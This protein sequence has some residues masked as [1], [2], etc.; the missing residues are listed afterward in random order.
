[1]FGDAVPPELHGTTNN[2]AY[3]H[4]SNMATVE[5]NWDLGN[6]GLGDSKAPAFF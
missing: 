5:R 3:N 4:Y 1:L 2:T 6:L